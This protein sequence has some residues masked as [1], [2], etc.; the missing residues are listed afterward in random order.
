MSERSLSD[1]SIKRTD[2]GSSLG[3]GGLN[4][5]AK[6]LKDS[7]RVKS[8]GTL[9]E[10]PPK[11]DHSQQ[12][13]EVLESTSEVLSE[14]RVPNSGKVSKST[15][16]LEKLVKSA[17]VEEATISDTVKLL[18]PSNK[19]ESARHH[20]FDPDNSKLLQ[21]FAKKE[22]SSENVNFLLDM[23]ALMTALETNTP[24]RDINGN[25]M[26][27]KN[28]EDIK[29]PTN[30]KEKRAFLKEHIY[31]KYISNSSETQINIPADIKKLI[32]K[33]LEP[34]TDI[35]FLE[36]GLHG[37]AENI[38]RLIKNDTMP[39]FLNERGNI[40]AQLTIN[41]KIKDLSPGDKI[42]ELEKIIED[43]NTVS[44][45]NTTAKIMVDEAKAILEP[46]YKE[47]ALSAIKEAVKDLPPKEK[48][49][50]L[51]QI[52]EGSKKVPLDGT[53][54]EVVHDHVESMINSIHKA[55]AKTVISEAV[56]GMTPREK[57]N[58]LDQ[59]MDGKK[60]LPTEGTSQKDLVKAAGNILDGESIWDDMKV[61]STIT[62]S[63]KNVSAGRNQL[64][65]LDKIMKGDKTFPGVDPEKSKEIAAIMKTE[66]L[67]KIVTND[68]SL[69]DPKK[70]DQFIKDFNKGTSNKIGITWNKDMDKVNDAM[71][72][73]QKLVKADPTNSSP[74]ITIKKYEA[75]KLL[76]ETCSNFV[77]NDSLKSESTGK[78]KSTKYDQVEALF[79]KLNN[80]DETPLEGAK[81]LKK[82][83]DT[84]ARLSTDALNLLTHEEA[85]G[86]NPAGD[87][88]SLGN[89][90][91]SLQP[92]L[93]KSAFARLET[94]FQEVSEKLRIAV[95]NN[96]PDG[97]KLALHELEVQ[98]RQVELLAKNT[99]ENSEKVTEA[100]H[101]FG[102]ES[103][104][105][106]F[107]KHPEANTP[108]LKKEALKKYIVDANK[109]GDFPLDITAMF[110][111]EK[112]VTGEYNKELKETQDR[113]IEKFKNG[114]LQDPEPVKS[115]FQLAIEGAVK[116]IAAYS[117]EQ[118]RAIGQSTSERTSH[119]VPSEVTVHWITEL[120]KAVKQEPDNNELKELLVNAKQH[121]MKHD[122]T[123]EKTKE[124]LELAGT[125]AKEAGRL[126]LEKLA[127][128]LITQLPKDDKDISLYR[129]QDNIYGRVFDSNVVNEMV[130]DPPESVKTAMA[131][132]KA[133]VFD[134][135]SDD[136]NI[137]N[138]KLKAGV[139]EFQKTLREKDPRFWF[140]NVPG[141]EAVRDAGTPEEA[142]QAFKNY[143]QAPVNNGHDSLSVPYAMCKFFL[144]LGQVQVVPD[145]KL[146][147][148]KNYQDVHFKVVGRTHLPGP[149]PKVP[150][151]EVRF[152]G[153]DHTKTKNTGITLN[154]Q[155][156]IG[157]EDVTL[158]PS[159]RPTTYNMAK[160][161]EG[162]TPTEVVKQA[163]GHGVPFASGV[164]G[165]TN[166]MMHLFESVKA[167]DPTVDVRDFLVGT[168][169]FL[170]HD[171]GH[172]IHE[173]MWTA[174]QLDKSMGLGLG[175]GDPEKPLDF[176]VDYNKVVA[177]YD[178]DPKNDI[179]KTKL[180][181]VMSTAFDNT[182]SYFDQ[183][184]YYAKK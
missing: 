83:N 25:I 148:D 78:V 182:S 183:N 50:A 53:T 44:L 1:I 166:I 21:A 144:A 123:L 84:I 16:V 49:D 103:V 20:L 177:L 37:A 98:S 90:I 24:P 32:T 141:L 79:R 104:T 156:G 147:G 76:K 131:K 74:E 161:A 40:A 3:E 150:N 77:I 127:K 42:K 85:E 12:L 140:P 15:K 122:M 158:N 121:F 38:L 33:A 181:Q 69:T 66:M 19:P 27:D 39:R 105:Q 18:K 82:S 165:S 61:Q 26:K 87:A 65:E 4:I 55:N 29:L 112:V 5:T 45:D 47:N 22:F 135:I 59:L 2:S 119:R 54:R 101:K 179:T 134:W 146:K 180:E 30:D 167:Q 160:I 133:V 88:R 96:D 118:T 67:N 100:L 10:D 124:L 142:L 48:L 106:F 64:N 110:A 58:F 81:T 171:G 75:L 46:I 143:L 113:N 138:E 17:G 89:T 51:V 154:H 145:W 153:V 99:P 14:V 93:S 178:K 132:T 136:T 34:T 71:K 56:K 63:L 7:D 62:R 155:P 175:L 114:E 35:K 139:V 176:V 52:F 111:Y 102:K 8:S 13:K 80:F 152:V 6:K 60:T 164:S 31:D 94:G 108:E 184:S 173:V 159:T 23:K 169:N 126:D 163:L 68:F 117:L 137:S 120:E 36:S 28:G 151:E 92:G 172:S 157:P 11:L 70:L 73:L 43:P 107:D 149:T 168:M 116:D 95:E 109:K 170:V 9:T 97:V 125:G 174:N 91:M 57:F 115:P 86:F 128:T 130:K 72:Q 41:E 129:L 162:D